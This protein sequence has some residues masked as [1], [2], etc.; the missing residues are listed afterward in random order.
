MQRYRI[1]FFVTLTTTV[2]FAG[3]L[4]VSWLNPP[5]LE[6]RTAWMT[7]WRG[8][9]RH[10]RG[11]PAATEAPSPQSGQPAVE[12]SLAP[13]TLTPQRMQSIGVRTGEVELAR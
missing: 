5:W 13:V 7:G 9:L 10:E 3:A 6:Q 1:A 8:I 2:L 12:T 11:D 4:I